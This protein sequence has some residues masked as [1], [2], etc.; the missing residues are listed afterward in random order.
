M[1]R[2][3]R[4]TRR[5]DDEEETPARRA[6]AQRGLPV[7]PIAIL[8]VLLGGA[9]F[10]ARV[11]NETKKDKADEPE[12]IDN[13]RVPFSDLPREVPTKGGQA[14]QPTGSSEPGVS[15]DTPP[16]G[17]LATNQVWLDALK[18]AAEAES[19]FL[20]AQN[21][22][23]AND[24]SAFRENGI[25]AK[26]LFSKVLEDTYVLEE[27]LVEEY[28]DRDAQVRDVIKKRTAWTKRLSTLSKT[29]GR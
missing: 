13:R 10:F 18:D 6:P 21:A 26:D 12:V 14:A 19:L 4:S 8:V 3:T 1:A 17:L 27:E 28:G 5:P 2:T 15:Y 23:A 7:A 20:A 29:T 25:A 11:I 24:H 22:K 9:L 16:T